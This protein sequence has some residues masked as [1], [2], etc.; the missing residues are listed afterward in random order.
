MGIPSGRFSVF[1]GLG[2][3]TR[4][5]GLVVLERRSEC[6][7]CLRCE[8]VSD[9]TPS[10][11]AVFLPRLSC[12]TRRTARHLADQELSKSRWSLW[13]AFVSPRREAW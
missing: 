12:V 11:P 2:I 5:T 6:A 3:Q 9:F 4:R 7:R 13:T 1:P 8:G 10:I